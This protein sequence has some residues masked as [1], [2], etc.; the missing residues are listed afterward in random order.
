MA[1]RSNGWTRVS[2]KYAL[3]VRIVLRRT[4]NPFW[5]NEVRVFGLR[6]RVKQA[7]AMVDRASAGHGFVATRR[8]GACLQGALV[9]HGSASVP[10]A[11]P[12]GRR[13]ATVRTDHDAKNASR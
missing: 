6:R 7:R 8:S 4:L 13:R 5:R 9:N 10:C 2:N 1:G 11:G 3:P 12:T